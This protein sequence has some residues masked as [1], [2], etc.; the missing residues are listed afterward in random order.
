MLVPSTSK[1]KRPL[2]FLE[3]RLLLDFFESCQST[4]IHVTT[5]ISTFQQ[6]RQNL[7]DPK[8][9]IHLAL[10]PPSRLI[11]TGPPQ[12][13]RFFVGSIEDTPEEPD[14]AYKHYLLVIQVTTIYHKPG[15]LK[16]VIR[17]FHFVF[18]SVIVLSTLS[19]GLL[20]R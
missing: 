3:W 11:L 7:P 13:Q 19:A 16:C 20:L 9:T 17:A 14:H 6:G 10:V 18:I 2:H 4:V 12:N 1:H 8:S 5:F 15:G